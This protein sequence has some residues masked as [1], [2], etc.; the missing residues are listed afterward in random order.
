M[1]TIEI[2]AVRSGGRGVNYWRYRQAGTVHWLGSV[3]RC[4]ADGRHVESDVLASYWRALGYH[5]TKQAPNGNRE[6]GHHST[7][8]AAEK[9]V[10]GYIAQLATSRPDPKC[11]VCGAACH[12]ADDAWVCVRRSCGSEWY[13]DHGPEYAPPGGAR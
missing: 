4:D 9:A 6:L 3:S 12:W 13:P 1:A 10:S 11:S 2:E 7:R 8:R 5:P